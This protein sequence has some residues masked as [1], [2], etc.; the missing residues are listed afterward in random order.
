L[1]NKLA[2]TLE[3]IFYIDE[4]SNDADDPKMARHLND[5]IEKVA[6][7]ERHLWSQK[8][9][10][11]EA[12]SELST[13]HW[14]E[15]PV[16]LSL[17]RLIRF[18]MTEVPVRT[19]KL[20]KCTAEVRICLPERPQDVDESRGRLWYAKV[21]RTSQFQSGPGLKTTTDSFYYVFHN[22]QWRRLAQDQVQQFHAALDSMAPE[23]RMFCLLKAEANMGVKLDWKGIQA[24]LADGL[25]MELLTERDIQKYNDEMLAFA[26]GMARQQEAGMNPKAAAAAAQ[27]L[28]STKVIMPPRHVMAGLSEYGIM[29]PSPVW[30]QFMDDGNE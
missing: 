3:E 12:E 23:L 22:L 16:G 29:K 9:K 20:K 21:L 14:T 30:A 13:N 2:S 4:H 6:S 1:V 11:L 15:P 24:A 27:R 25:E 19:K 7:A 26:L 18:H 5:L 8:A 10:S 28:L 17:E